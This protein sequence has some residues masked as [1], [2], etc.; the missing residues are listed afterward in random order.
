MSTSDR[1]DHDQGNKAGPGPV[2]PSLDHF[3]QLILMDERTRKAWD[4]ANT[5]TVDPEHQKRL[6]KERNDL[7]RQKP[8]KKRS[9]K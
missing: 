7:L 5:G 6:A 3:F 9:D 4:D 8:A 1:S 2:T